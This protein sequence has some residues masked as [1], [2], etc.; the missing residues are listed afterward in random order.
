MFESG[1]DYPWQK[2]RR[3]PKCGGKRLWWHSF[4]Q[5]SF[6][7]YAYKV[8]VKKCICIDCKSV[9]TMRPYTHWARFQYSKFIII[10]CLIG[11]TKSCRWQSGIKRQNQQYWYKGVR[12][13]GLR[14]KNSDVI[15]MEVLKG[16]FMLGIIPVNHSIQCEILRL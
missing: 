7:N 14:H 3:C 1:K 6:N 4:V 16:L 13:Q 12:L 8:W 11:K 5:R 10:S 9:H 15:T 2:P